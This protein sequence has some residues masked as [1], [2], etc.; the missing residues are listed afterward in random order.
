MVSPMQTLRHVVAGSDFSEH[1]DAALELGRKHGD[2]NVQ[3]IALT[4]K[5]SALVRKGRWEEGLALFD[6]ATASAVSG[7]LDPKTACDVYC[8]TIATCR[9][10][11][12]YARAAQWTEQADRF[13]ARND[14]NGYRGACRL[15]RAELKR[16]HGSWDEAEQEVLD[17]CKE[18]EDF[19]LLDITGEAYYE[20]GELR[21]NMGDIDRA[22]EAFHRAYGFGKTPQPGLALVQ[23]ARG[24]LD[25]AGESITRALA[26]GDEHDGS[27]QLERARMLPARVEI[28]IA[29]DDLETAR[30]ALA[31]LDDI[32]GRFASPSL[33]AG[34]LTAHGRL[35]LAE[36]RLDAAVRTFDRAW[37]SWQEID[38]PFESARARMLLGVARIEAGDRST[39]VLDVKAARSVFER[40]GARRDL[41]QADQVLGGETAPATV[42]VTRTFMFTDIVTST[43][44]LE[45]IG[46]QA[47]EELLRWHDRTLRET[48]IRHGGQ[49]V[50]KLGDG[51]FVSFTQAGP[52]LDCAMAV[53]QRLASHR[54][55]H[56]FA[57]WVR[58]GVHTSE[59]GHDG[60]DYS[61]L[62]VHLAARVGGAADREEILVSEAARQ[63]AGPGDHVFS[64]NRRVTVKGIREPVEVHTLEWR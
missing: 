5:G 18:L 33:S 17:A 55:E 9:E 54:R 32:A 2:T 51:F 61:G 52:A 42:R 36:A 59:A 40:L 26:P 21:L 6:E 11:A 62:G 53:Q 49:E 56:G 31:E 64:S 24:R 4:F 19:R 15:H 23:L 27:D 38:L 1:A 60:D 12:D 25:E 20:L 39:G 8:N 46:D 22:E 63:A 45:L 14:I 41:A 29:G 50:R 30:T 57:P 28:A 43:D 58:I 10:L 7:E 37:R 44:L 3:S 48:F 34:A 35:E 47:W 13:M 16:L